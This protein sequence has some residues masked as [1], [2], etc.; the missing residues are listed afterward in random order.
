MRIGLGLPH[1]GPLAD[2]S[3]IARFA[4]AAEELGYTSLWTGDRVLAPVRP[5]DI[6]PGGGT[7]ERPYPPEY[8]R[9]LDPLVALTVAATTTSTI[10]LGTSTLTGTLHTPVLLG[11]SLTSLD[12]VSGGRLDVG[13][14]IGWLRDEYAAAGVPWADRGKRLD[15]LIDA[16]LALWT[17]QPV[18]HHGHFWDIPEST[19]D[20]RPVQQPRPPILLGGFSAAALE[21]IGRRADG[22]LMAGFSPHLLAEQWATIRAAA[23]RAG[24]DPSAV[25][26]VLRLNPQQPTDVAEVTE[27]LGVAKELAVDEAF[28][29]L[30]FV[31]TDID[32]AL[33][34]ATALRAQIPR[35]AG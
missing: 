15:E 21:R 13:L 30:H 28:V 32:D 10:R 33:A 35:L 1:Y 3:G 26:R 5:S 12:Q 7:P 6:Y 27:Q 29:D 24:R 23:E 4:A 18:E 14:G 16:L 31:A 9:F 22:W 11:R 20:L 25:R 19:V 2:A 17:R 34:Y 8:T